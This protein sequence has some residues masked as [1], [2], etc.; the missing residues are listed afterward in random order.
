MLMLMLIMQSRVALICRF[1]EC[2]YPYPN[3]MDFPR[4][5][6]LSLSSAKGNGGDGG[7]GVAAVPTAPKVQYRVTTVERS[8]VGG[9][10]LGDGKC[11]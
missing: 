10:C 9:V 5:S 11:L 2:E 7:G 6:N 8:L 4:R 1:C 3:V